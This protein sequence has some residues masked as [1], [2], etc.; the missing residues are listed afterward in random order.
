MAA[1]P[2]PK[3]VG[4]LLMPKATPSASDLATQ[5]ATPT[6]VFT[7]DNVTGSVRRAIDDSVP[8]LS[9]PVLTLRLLQQG[10]GGNIQAFVRA[11]EPVLEQDL[12]YGSAVDT[13][14]EAL[15]AAPLI[16]EPAGQLARD[17]RLA[18]EVQQVILDTEPLLQIVRHLASSE[19]FGFAVAEN[20]WDTSGPTW[21]LSEVVAVP[22]GWITFD[23]NDGRTP[24][25]LPGDA[26]KAATPLTWGKYIYCAM[27]GYGLP[28]LRSHG[29]A[30]A[31]YNSLK[32]MSDKSW[33]EFLEMF[34][35]PMR[36]GTWDPKAVPDAKEREK[37]KKVLR[38]A[39]Q[40]IGRDAWAMLPAGLEI[41]LLESATKGAS[42]DLYER[43]SRYTDE[44]I[45]KRKTGSVLATGTGNTGSGGSQAL[46][47]V[48]N[49]AFLRK[50]RALGKRIA[51]AIRRYVV[52]PYVRFNYG[53]DTPVPFVAFHFEEPEDIA[54]LSQALERL[55]PLGLEVSQEEI[56]DKLGL[57]APADGE[58]RLVPQ[59]ASA[60]QEPAP[61]GDGAPAEQKNTAQRLAAD[62]EGERDELDD[63]IDELM[64]EDGF[65]RADADAD[66]QL[67]AA[68]ES[69]GNA[70]QLRRALI[71]A[72]RSGNVDGLQA[73]FTAGT[74][75]AKTA[76]DFGAEIGDD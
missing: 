30:A 8:T 27:P 75:A 12:N 55:V 57:R 65:A 15:T 60:P 11:V 38:D 63:L 37:A 45:T 67:L 26:G 39:L 32:N 28:I 69:A 43:F 9:S 61:A 52:E 53:P 42:S 4:A 74:T 19:D 1:N 25:L 62:G 47:N 6:N 24:L 50:V 66:E 33:S 3:R 71:A 2:N 56:R 59:A 73:V 48:H 51:S 68:I 31:F 20:I 49:E 17:K 64:Q 23:K 7:T 21:K 72:V 29:F 22:P 18:A 70:D 76:G 40:N 16:A 41:K 5:E 35:Q 46:G 44:L 14:V 13:V 58:A 34:G 10:R 36:Q 54:V